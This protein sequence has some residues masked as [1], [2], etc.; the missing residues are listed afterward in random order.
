LY[1]PW[2]LSGLRNWMSRT[3]RIYSGKKQVEDR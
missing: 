2:F 3:G 1:S